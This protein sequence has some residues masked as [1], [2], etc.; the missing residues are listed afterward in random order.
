MVQ[1]HQL[2]TLPM[3][4]AISPKLTRCLMK[5]CS[6]VERLKH[7]RASHFLLPKVVSFSVWGQEFQS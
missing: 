2:R 4:R 6:E 7:K 5:T 1:Q 3:T